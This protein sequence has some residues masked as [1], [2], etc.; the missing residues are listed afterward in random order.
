[1]K[2]YLGYFLIKGSNKWMKKIFAFIMICMTMFLSACG[3]KIEKTQYNESPDIKSKVVGSRDLK[4]DRENPNTLDELVEKTDVS[5]IC[6][7]IGSGTEVEH[8]FIAGKSTDKVKQGIENRLP[9]VIC[10]VAKVKVIEVV[11]GTLNVGDELDIIQLGE[12]WS[13]HGQ[14]KL[15]YGEKVL[16]LLTQTRTGYYCGTDLENSFFYINNEKITSMSDVI[17]CARYD[18]LPLNTL[19]RDLMQTQRFKLL[20]GE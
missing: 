17:V 18:D 9:K 15:V 20:N 10:T 12:P 5:I 3:S 6:E 7:V 2:L 8:E 14:T 11:A 13:N 19:I 16:C 4:I 1:M